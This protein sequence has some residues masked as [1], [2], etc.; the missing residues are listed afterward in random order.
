MSKYI[1]TTKGIFEYKIDMIIENAVYYFFGKFEKTD[2]KHLFRNDKDL[3]EVI[4]EADTIE[5]L[6]D[7]FRYEYD[8]F[9]KHERCYRNTDT[10]EW[11]DYDIDKP[12]KKILGEISTVRG[13][14]WVGM[15]LINVAKTNDKG[16]LELI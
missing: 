16:E 15:D 14:I 11:C 12:L 4:K 7:E 6:C 10:G 13:Y 3:G 8:K 5:E 1:R 9:S 2:K